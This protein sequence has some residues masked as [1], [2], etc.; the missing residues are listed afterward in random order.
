MSETKDYIVALNKQVLWIKTA[1]KVSS[2]GLAVDRIIYKYFHKCKSNKLMAEK[3]S[4][5][6]QEET[7]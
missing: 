4:E 2:Y 1:I 3:E 5:D 6:E 7:E